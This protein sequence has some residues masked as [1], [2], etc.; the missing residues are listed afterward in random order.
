MITPAQAVLFDRLMR[1][2]ATVT[3]ATTVVKLA[4]AIE[5]AW[6]D[7]WKSE[8]RGKGGRWL[9]PGDVSPSGTVKIV[10]TTTKVTPTASRPKA[11][12][13]KAAGIPPIPGLNIP[14]GK[15]VTGADLA[16]FRTEISNSVTKAF[17]D[18]T[19]ASETRVQGKAEALF[20]YAQLKQ[21]AVERGRL[22]KKS[23]TK[24]AIEIG[25]SVGGL[26][27]AV[28]EGIIGLPGL[29]QVVSAMAPPV[30]QAIMEWRKRL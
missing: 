16:A 5:L 17:V 11:I 29:S 4:T 22:E 26:V 19:T 20:N 10:P 1:D 7:A 23:R 28:L 18:M 15:Q 2:G 27:L 21:R 13:A 30:A 8:L 25:I 12:T 6:G 3:E 24:A 14:E 9:S